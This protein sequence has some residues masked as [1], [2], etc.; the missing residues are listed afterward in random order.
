MRRQPSVSDGDHCTDDESHH[1]VTER[2]GFDVH[3]R[4]FTLAFPPQLDEPADRGGE[5]AWFAERGEVVFTKEPL[6]RFVHCI[7]VELSRMSKR[8]VAREWIG[9]GGAV[10]DA[11]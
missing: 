7:K 5:L 11:I 1:R 9:T 8:N 6:R 4:E 10:A 3:H 2:I